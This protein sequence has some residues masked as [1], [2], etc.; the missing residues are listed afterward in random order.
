[1]TKR[2][3]DIRK[4]LFEKVQTDIKGFIISNRNVTMTIFFLKQ[5]LFYF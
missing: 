4:T 3:Y 1:M 2:H 5:D